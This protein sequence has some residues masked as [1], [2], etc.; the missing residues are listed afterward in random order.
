MYPP[1]I[2]RLFL[3]NIRLENLCR[4]LIMKHIQKFR[5]AFGQTSEK[6]PFKLHS[7]I[8]LPEHVHILI[9]MSK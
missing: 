2:Q 7:M 5:Q 3:S 6:H 8:A 9:T 1:R 4:L